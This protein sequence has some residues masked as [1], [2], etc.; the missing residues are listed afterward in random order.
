VL[1]VAGGGFGAVELRLHSG[2][3]GGGAGW[4]RESRIYGAALAFRNG[5]GTRQPA[6]IL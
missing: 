1:A 6:R 4:T 3:R 2:S 5:D